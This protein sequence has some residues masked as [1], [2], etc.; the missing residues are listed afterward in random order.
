MR[1]CRVCGESKEPEVFGLRN[2]A[3]GQRHRA[4]KQCAA[5]YGR[6]HYTAHRA[7]YV[8]RNRVLARTRSRELRT[9]LAAY[10]GERACV[11]CGQADPRVLDFDHIDPATKRDTIHALVHQAVSWEALLTEIEQC[12]VRCANCHR[13]R[14]AAQFGWAKAHFAAEA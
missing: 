14:T 6:R 13:R 7:E 11:D 5:A 1:T 2:R 3:T 9:Q 8:A 4:C 12:Q 10:L